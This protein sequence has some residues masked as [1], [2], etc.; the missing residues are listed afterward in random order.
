MFQNMGE[1]ITDYEGGALD[2]AE[3]RLAL[4]EALSKILKVIFSCYIHPLIS[5]NEKLGLFF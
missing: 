2:A 3:V 1:L 4:T 5:P